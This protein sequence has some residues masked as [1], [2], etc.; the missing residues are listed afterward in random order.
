MPTTFLMSLIIFLVGSIGSCAA[1]E[2]HMVHPQTAKAKADGH[3]PACDHSMHICAFHIAKDNPDVIFETQHFCVALKEDLFQCIL[4]ETTAK[5]LQ[6]KLIGIEYVISDALYQGLSKEEQTLWHPHDFEVHQG[7]LATIDIPPTEEHKIM[8]A[9][10]KTWGKTWHTW[11][12]VKTDLP[13]GKPRLMWSATKPGQ[14]PEEMIQARDRRWG[15]DT[16]KL[17]KERDTYLP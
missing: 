3:N 8:K 16:S 10:V 13:L 14:I 1:V 9:L 12:D 2:E 5:G 11:P 7:L 6:P 17:K 4:Y 15:I